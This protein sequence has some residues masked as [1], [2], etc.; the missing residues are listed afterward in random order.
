MTK[1]I[2]SSTPIP[3][4]RALLAGSPAA[5]AG[6]LL[7]GTAANSLAIAGNADSDLLSLAAEFSPL[8]ASWRKMT[9]KQTADLDAFN[10]FLEQEAGMSRDEAY[11]L[12]RD[13]P[14]LEAYREILHRCASAVDRPRRSYESEAWE[15]VKDRFYELAEDILSYEA[16]TREGLALQATAFVSSY[17]EVWESDD[18]VRAFVE[19][20]CAFAGVP[21]PPVPEGEQA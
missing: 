11:C 5:A 17:S 3:T 21:F 10:E 15:P 14:E 4:R 12:D 16:S 20:V 13:S 19:C 8:F 18:G 1:A 7:A 9:I 6:A 2:D